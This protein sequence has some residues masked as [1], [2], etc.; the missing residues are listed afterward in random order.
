M[1]R[2][3]S[4]SP[5][6]TP[7]YPQTPVDKGELGRYFAA[8]HQAHQAGRLQEAE[9]GYRRLLAHLPTHADSLHLLGM[10]FHQQGDHTQAL[11]W[12]Q[13]A[14]S[15]KKDGRYFGNLGM[16]LL[17]LGQLGSA[18]AALGEALQMNPDFVEA[19]F[20]LGLV[21]QNQKRLPQAE[22]AFRRAIEIKPSFHPALMNLGQLLL[23]RGDVARAAEAFEQVTRLRL[24]LASAHCNLGLAFYTFTEERS[25]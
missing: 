7:V 4:S 15:L 11:E 5:K 18:E 23:E 3:L 25:S 2:S 17:K 10:V 12:I 24:D 22:A 9:A 16:V 8:A 13:R 21:L 6:P 14:I 20:R 19:H 1:T